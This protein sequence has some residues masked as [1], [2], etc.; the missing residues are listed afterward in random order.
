MGEQLFL[1]GVEASRRPTDGLFF[2]VLPDEAA[3]VDIACVAQHQSRAHGLTGKPIL[4]ERLHVSLHN[5]GDY[6]GRPRGIIAA[7][8]EAA[9]AVV[10]PSFDVAFDRVVSF[11]GRSGNRHSYCAAA[12][13]SWDCWPCIGILARHCRKSACGAG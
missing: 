1:V 11:G 5:I 7:G 9:S 4:A 13:V 3:A 10:M 12:I 8:C 6:A 2:W